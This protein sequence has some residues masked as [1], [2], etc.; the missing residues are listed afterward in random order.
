MKWGTFPERIRAL[1]RYAGRFEAFRL[2]ADRCEVLFGTYPSGTRIE[3]HAHA[4][5][6]WGVITRGEMWITQGGVERRFGPGDWYHVAPGEEHAARCEVDT[7]EVEFWFE[8]DVPR[9]RN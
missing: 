8:A 5:D 9:A 7:E 2:Q 4:T 3:P 1:E 6:N